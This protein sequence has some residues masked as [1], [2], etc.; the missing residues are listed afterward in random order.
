MQ[1]PAERTFLNQIDEIRNKIF[2]ITKRI[3]VSQEEAE[4][5]TQEVIVKLWEMD[6]AKRDGFKSIEAYSVT[7]AKNYCLDRL[8]SKQA[9]NLSLDERLVNAPSDSL[10]KKIEQTDE[11]NLVG[12]LIDKL[13][14]RERMIIQLR[15]IEQYDFNEIASILNLPEGTIRVYLSRTRKKLRKQFTE[16]QNHGN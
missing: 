5:A 16:M 3:L 6:A 2:R 15:E 7:M 14:E 13:P 10:Q 9:Q 12:G 1:L 8:K 4:D 11:L